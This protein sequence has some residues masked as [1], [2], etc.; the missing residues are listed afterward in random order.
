[1]LKFEL[2]TNLI[3]GDYLYFPTYH[4]I[5]YNKNTRGS[6]TS[7]KLYDLICILHEQGHHRTFISLSKQKQELYVE[8]LINYTNT[9]IATNGIL[10][11]EIKAWKNVFSCTNSSIHD[12]IEEIATLALMSYISISKTKNNDFWITYAKKYWER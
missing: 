5:H 7:G 1:M 3:D 6:L 12:C 8:E 2:D 4:C 11:S 10:L 9:H